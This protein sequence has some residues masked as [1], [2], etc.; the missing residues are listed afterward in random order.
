M[1]N[2]CS[3]SLD[4]TIIPTV[5]KAIILAS[6]SLFMQR[7][8]ESSRRQTDKNSTTQCL[9]LVEWMHNHMYCIYIVYSSGSKPEVRGPLLG[10]PRARPP[11]KV[12]KS[13]EG[14][15]KLRNICFK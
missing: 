7:H 6:F 14:E 4:K 5:R 13:S 11:K 15:I 12:E 3:A 10:G 8:P 9:E 1:I 2:L